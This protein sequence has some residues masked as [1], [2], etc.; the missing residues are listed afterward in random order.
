[1]TSKGRSGSC[2]TWQLGHGNTNA[3]KVFGSTLSRGLT[4]SGHGWTRQ[5]RAV[6]GRNVMVRQL[7]VAQGRVRTYTFLT[8]EGQYSDIEERTRQGRQDRTSQINIQNH[9]KL[10]GP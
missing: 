8:R 4:K 10:Q 9:T 6:H 5:G 3:E 7:R 2:Y 1:M